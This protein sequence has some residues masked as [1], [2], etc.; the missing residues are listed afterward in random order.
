[1]SPDPVRPDGDVAVRVVAAFDDAA[2][3]AALHRGERPVRELS[4]WL[5]PDSP[6]WS[7]AVDLLP[8]VPD[9]TDHV[10]VVQP[11]FTAPLAHAE[12]TERRWWNAAGGGKPV[13]YWPHPR[14]VVE[15]A[16]D[17]RPLDV[18]P[19]D[20][21]ALL[22]LAG[23]AE[24]VIDTYVDFSYKKLEEAT[25][26]WAEGLAGRVARWEDLVETW[27]SDPT[28]FDDFLESGS[29][30]DELPQLESA[31]RALRHHVDRN[32][33]LRPADPKAPRP[34]P[35]TELH[36]LNPALAAADD[37]VHAALDVTVARVLDGLREQRKQN[38]RRAVQDEAAKWVAEHGS[39]R[40]KMAVEAGIL[41]QA[42]GAFRDER[43]RAEHPG[44][45]WVDRDD[46][47]ELDNKAM[48]P[49][50]DAIR[51]LLDARQT[52]NDKAYLAYHAGHHL[53]FLVAGFLDRRIWRPVDPDWAAENLEGHD[54][55]TI[56]VYDALV[57]NAPPV[58]Y[59]DAEEPF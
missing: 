8:E 10:L 25:R 16:S 53:Q 30:Y 4:F 45:M 22:E 57:R 41:D 48:N 44:W 54:T 47:S 9:D 17:P 43:L 46:T 39:D 58:A 1:M 26:Q 3:R 15:R 40:L 33:Q 21:A 38:E 34:R 32:D 24:D 11:E 36:V 37:A 55:L 50:E 31:L 56:S 23:K 49:S 52:V 18:W 35:I 2:A 42:M 19:E 13:P 12:P 51:L 27:K 5:T 7:D 59:D 20:T 29:A 28:I 6:H 14:I